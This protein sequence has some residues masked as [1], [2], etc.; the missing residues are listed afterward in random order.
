[1]ALLRLDAIYFLEYGDVNST[2]ARLFRFYPQDFTVRSIFLNS[3][4]NDMLD[5]GVAKIFNELDNISSPAVNT[6]RYE[7]DEMN[8]LS[9]QVKS[10][11][12]GFESFQ[13]KIAVDMS[14]L[15]MKVQ[16][17]DEASFELLL[18][19]FDPVSYIQL[20]ELGKPYSFDWG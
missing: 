11:E 20:K 3:S 2:I 7:L 6:S 15:D 17:E 4:M 14:Y 19:K 1:M 18:Q 5:F 9:F 13:G 16:R 12:Q 8:S 10:P